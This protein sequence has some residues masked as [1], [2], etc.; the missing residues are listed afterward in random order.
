MRYFSVTCM[1][2]HCGGR[3]FMPIT[4]AF[5]AENAME[6]MDKAKAMPGVKH[7]RPIMGLREITCKEYYM[8]RQRSAYE[9]AENI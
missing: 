5:A 4:F 3:K 9:R 1:R 8:L 2:G 7:D 6:A